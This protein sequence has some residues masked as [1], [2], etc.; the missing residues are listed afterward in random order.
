MHCLDVTVTVAAQ[1]AL[2]FG[3][4]EEIELALQVPTRDDI[5][6]E[7]CQT[8]RAA[9][10]S[11]GSVYAKVGQ[12]FELFFRLSGPQ[13]ERALVEIYHPSAVAEVD[14][15]RPEARFAVMHKLRLR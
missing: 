9:R 6:V 7:L 8:R 12:P 11:G 2:Q 3:G 1:H 13:D 15:C 10:I 5:R 4:A 14:P